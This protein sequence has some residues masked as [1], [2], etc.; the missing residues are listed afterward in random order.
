LEV[1]AV[2]PFQKHVGLSACGRVS[3]PADRYSEVF[4]QNQQLRFAPQKTG[5]RRQ[6][7]LITPER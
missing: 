5:G 6:I 4:Q 3:D 2:P 1:G 7:P